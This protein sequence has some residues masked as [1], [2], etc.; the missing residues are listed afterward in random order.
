[1]SKLGLIPLHLGD[2]LTEGGGGAFGP[3]S[4]EGFILDAAFTLHRMGSHPP[5]EEQQTKML[6][7][8]ANPN[9]PGLNPAYNISL[10]VKFQVTNVLDPA[11][12]DGETFE[13]TWSLGGKSAA[14]WYA[15]GLPD[16]TVPIGL[17]GG[18]QEQVYLAIG[19]YDA[20]G[21][22]QIL[23]LKNPDLSVYRGRWFQPLPDVPEAKRK[24][25][26]KSGYSVF[27]TESAAVV[28]AVEPGLVSS[29]TELDEKT[30]QP[31]VIQFLD[32]F[33]DG[34][35]GEPLGADYFK[36]LSGIWDTKPVNTF[37]RKG[38]KEAQTQKVLCLTTFAGRVSVSQVAGQAEMKQAG[39]GT[40][41]K[42]TSKKATTTP[43]ST[44][45]TDAPTTAAGNGSLSV[46]DR[47]KSLILDLLP[48]E[49]DETSGRFK[50][51]M[52]Q[53]A[54]G[55]ELAV[56]KKGLAGGVFTQ[57]EVSGGGLVMFKKILTDAPDPDSAAI[58][59]AE[60]GFAY[61]P[62]QKVVERWEVATE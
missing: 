4:F 15:C 62:V 46:E 60:S 3:T 22:K 47:I 28:A 40:T 54:D 45:P 49:R 55:L 38:E 41:N 31:R 59:G 17:D 48:T 5:T 21:K 6:A 52:A 29:R 58:V 39:A 12:W 43:A 56:F 8:L 30:K 18:F 2:I 14:S 35:D 33:L 26:T 25:N 24:L 53:G 16:P 23:H 42:S 50:G 7:S 36:G 11:D 9:A 34:P 27:C 44:P 32:C 13:H 37:Q 20:A 19:W 57:K 61:N 51:M 10:W 1:M